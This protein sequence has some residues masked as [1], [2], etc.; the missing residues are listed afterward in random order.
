MPKCPSRACS[1]PITGPVARR[2]VRVGFYRRKHS[3]RSIQRYRCRTCRGYFSSQ[4][5]DPTYY[6]KRPDLNFKVYQLLA[7]AVSQ[8]RAAKLLG[9]SRHTVVRKFRFMARWAG[10][11]NEKRRII[12]RK[13][14]IGRVQ[15][16]D[17]VTSLHSKCKPLSV[18]LA[19]NSETRE[20]LGF[21]V[22]NIPARHPLIEVS[23]R[24]YG[25]IMD[26]RPSGLNR[27]FYN[28]RGVVADNSTFRSDCDPE[29]PAHVRR[30]FMLAK[31]ETFKS[32][33]GRVAGFGEL[34]RIGFDPIFSLNHTCAMLRANLNRLARKTWCTTKSK[35]GLHLHLELYT[36]FHNT[37]LIRTSAT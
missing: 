36:H 29:Y 11:E 19:V 5:N 14:P 26:E 32:R 4:T 37:E 35:I 9:V 10:I 24:K 7:S 23:L 27:L 6:Q 28:L 21:Q 2:I 30:H 3:L 18:S 16:D 12:I 15:F 33:R 20:I 17:L 13:N 31:H 8:R 34:K 1:L 25:Q 22:S